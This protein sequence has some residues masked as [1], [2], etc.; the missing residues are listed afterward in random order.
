[1]LSIGLRV[2]RSRHIRKDEG[3]SAA[4]S[5]GVLEQRC[6][7]RSHGARPTRFPALSGVGRLGNGI[8]PYSENKELRSRD[9]F[10]RYAIPESFNSPRELV[11]EMCSSMVVKVIG[12]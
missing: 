2:E 11:G 4:V 8:Q 10:E 12:S 1:L 9:R 6:L 7:G 5:P 3:R